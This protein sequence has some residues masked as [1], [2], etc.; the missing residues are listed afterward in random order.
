[1]RWLLR[2]SSDSSVLCTWLCCVNASGHACGFVREHTAVILCAGQKSVC[3]RCVVE[4][5]NVA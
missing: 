4:T 2:L 1:M 3:L 5:P